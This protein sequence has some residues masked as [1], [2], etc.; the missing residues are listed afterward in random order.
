M[1]LNLF[2]LHFYQLSGLESLTIIFIDK[3][4]L[5]RRRGEEEN[6]ILKLI[7]INWSVAYLSLPLTFSSRVCEIK[8]CKRGRLLDGCVEVLREWQSFL[9]LQVQ[10]L[11]YPLD[12]FGD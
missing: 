5:G 7:C 12:G 1:N 10:K 11:F 4:S 9:L 3:A 6:R 8:Q 2:I